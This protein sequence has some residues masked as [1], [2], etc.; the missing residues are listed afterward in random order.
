MKKK[1]EIC[2]KGLNKKDIRFYKLVYKLPL[3]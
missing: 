3:I 1:K 2:E